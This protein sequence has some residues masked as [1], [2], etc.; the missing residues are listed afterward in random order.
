MIGK[1]SRIRP[2]GLRC[3][4]PRRVLADRVLADRVLADRVLADRAVRA[5]AGAAYLAFASLL[6]LAAGC[7]Q[8]DPDAPAAE[9]PYYPLVPGAWWQYAH[10][11]WTERVETAT[12]TFDGHDA[13]L[14]TDSP[15]P[16]DGLRSVSTIRSIDGNVVRV[17]KQE[18]LM[19]GANPLLTSSVTYGVGFTRFN[20]NWASQPVGYKD[21]PEYVRVETSPDGMVGAPEARKHTFEI[22]SL[23]ES[24]VTGRGS[25]DCIVIQRTKDWQ[26]EAAGVDVSDAQTKRFWFARGVGKVQERNLETGSTELLIDYSIPASGG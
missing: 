21:T 23:A 11:D 14:M 1:L 26:A 8:K 3:Y 13:I 25:F 2:S 17:A 6:G 9:Q 16:S 18:Y 5:L 20:E 24:V 22:I 4:A 10:S 12:A 15:N 19:D 7:G